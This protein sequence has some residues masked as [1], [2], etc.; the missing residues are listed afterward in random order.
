MPPVRPWLDVRGNTQMSTIRIR[1]WHVLAVFLVMGALVAG[2]LAFAATNE[3]ATPV[4]VGVPLAAPYQEP[5]PAHANYLGWGQVTSAAGNSWATNVRR[6]TAWEWN[7]SRGWIERSRTSGTRV[8]IY[9]YGSGW[10]WTWTQSTGWLAMR[11]NLLTIGYRP[12]AIAT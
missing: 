2:A 10:S 3:A 9:P 4:N 11:T 6:H 1:T 7:T 8:Y 12:I 5:I